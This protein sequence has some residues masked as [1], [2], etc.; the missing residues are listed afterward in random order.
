MLIKC[1]FFSFNLP[2][3]YAQVLALEAPEQQPQKHKTPSTIRRICHHSNP[4]CELEPMVVYRGR[5][6]ELNRL[7][8]LDVII[9]MFFASAILCE[10]AGSL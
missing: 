1:Q 4:S 8:E 7:V 6:V 5:V 9:L 2:P 3:I 10:D